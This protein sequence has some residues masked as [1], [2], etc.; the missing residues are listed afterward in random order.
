[1]PKNKMNKKKELLNSLG[2]VLIIAIVIA[3]VY[4][5]SGGISQGVAEEVPLSILKRNYDSDQIKN[6]RV[7]GSK[8]FFTLEDGSEKFS[9][10]ENGANLQDLGIDPSKVNV[11]IIDTAKNRFWI[12]LGVSIIPIALIFIFLLFIFKQAQGSSNSA[13][14]FGKSKAQLFETDKKK[15]VMFKDVA[16]VKEA[17]EE[18]EEIVDFLKHPKKYINMGAKIP[19]GVIMF[20]PPGTGKTLLA[21]AVAGEAKVPFFSIAG[22]EFVEMFVGVGASRVRDLFSK[23]KK[24]APCIIF[25][26]EIDAVGRHRGAGV[27]GGHDEREQTLNQILVEMDGFDNETNVIVMAATNRPDILDPAIL[28]P[29]RFDRRVTIDLPDLVSR[30]EILKVHSHD[31]PF[32][33]GV[34]LSKIAKQTPGFSGADLASLMNE[35]AI[36]AARNGK[37]TISMSDLEQSIEKVLLGPERKSKVLSD[38]ER[39]I[40]AYHEAGH[41]VVGHFLLHCDPVHKISIVSRGMA[42]GVTWYMPEK[43]LHLYSRTKFKHE[44]SA[45]LGGRVAEELIFKEITTGASNDLERATDIAKRMVTIYGMS[46]KLGLQ[47]YSPGNSTVFLG[48]ELTGQKSYSDSVAEMIDTEV[49]TIIKEAYMN[50]VKILKS[51]SKEL[52]KVAQLLLK[53]ET[54]NREEFLELVGKRSSKK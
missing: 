9:I 26:D 24:N 32:V 23:A 16:G 47:V 45:V 6:I 5:L 7:E 13:F 30:E 40:T 29:G 17:K 48:R 19:T 3:S 25:I 51:K 1:M 15:K 31:K 53:K 2:I 43:D 28:R 50:T 38:E 4:T 14:S 10:K 8:L 35:S 27:G 21:R 44:L 18:L 12:D 42:L 36:L 54:I 41:A 49:S 20:G 22:S 33:K 52:E 39:K 46:D 37:K 11:N 34:D